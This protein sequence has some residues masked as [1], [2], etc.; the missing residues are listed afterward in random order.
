MLDWVSRL[1][2]DEAKSIRL[3][4]GKAQFN[5]MFQSLAVG[6]NINIDDETDVYVHEWFT[7]RKRAMLDDFVVG[8]I[9]QLLLAALKQK[10]VMM[11]HLGLANKIVIIDE[12]HAFDAY[13]NCYLERA[14]NWLGT[15]GVPVVLLSATLP[16]EKRRMVIEAYCNQRVQSAAKRGMSDPLGRS[17]GDLPSSQGVRSEIPEW[18]SSRAYPLVTYT[19]GRKVRQAAVSSSASSKQVDIEI[20][21]DAEISNKLSFLLS[22]G[23]C[24]G[25][26]VNSVRRAQQ[27]AR[28]LK[29]TFG[30][31]EVH[32]LH[33]RFLTPDRIAKEETLLRE[34]GKPSVSR[35]RPA[36]R[37]IVGTQVLE[38][39]LDIDFDVLITDICPMDLLLQRIGRLHRH[40]RQRPPRLQRALCLV[41]GITEDGFDSASTAIYGEY[42]LMR[43]KACLP[44]RL[45]LPDDIPNL[46]Q[47]VYDTHHPLV[48]DSDT[49]RE[50]EAEYNRL[51]E[52]KRSRADAFRMRPP[53]E[54]GDLIGWLD[55]DVP[56]K[57]GEASVRDTE[58][59]FEVLL[60]RSTS[61]GK[62]GF[63]PWIEK[64]LELDPYVEP[65]DDVAQKL[66]CCSVRLPAAL[67][68][69]FRK[70]DETI[71][72]LEQMNKTRLGVWQRSPWLRGEL[73][74]ILDEHL[75]M[76][77]GKYRITYHREY[78]LDY[79]VKEEEADCDECET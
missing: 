79:T 3:M 30:E 78:G 67:C 32:L 24:A 41:T 73:F 12:C 46:V 60:I 43:T 1:E 4:H 5:R 50:A 52:Q 68:G 64:G 61:S 62:V 49:Y 37:I 14:L 18:V 26:I 6:S 77:F 19:D 59:S 38:Q 65:P 75:S 2:K 29:D 17:R 48:Q 21:D 27:L 58:D 11:R 70:L 35:I 23:G 20:L 51:L 8:T 72:Q 71:Q 66:A 57:K 13:M 34:L 45:K 56:D 31:E 33:S 22:D 39:S 36:M 54:M 7:G 55:T 15:Y 40:R 74:L 76:N 69:R 47:D 53:R 16:A 9:D 63:L 28:L 42:L 44:E 10:H 25:I